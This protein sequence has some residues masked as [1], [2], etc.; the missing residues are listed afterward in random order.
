M[1]LTEAT[2]IVQSVTNGLLTIVG[3]GAAVALVLAVVRYFTNGANPN[4][5]QQLITRCIHVVG[6][7]ACIGLVL[8]FSAPFAASLM[9]NSTSSEIAS[10]AK[11][12]NS[13][14]PQV[15][16]K[17]KKHTVTEGTEIAKSKNLGEALKKAA[18]AQVAAAGL[19][20]GEATRLDSGAMVREMLDANNK[21]S[22]YKCCVCGKLFDKKTDAISCANA[23]AAAA[24]EESKNTVDEV[25]E[26]QKEVA[27]SGLTNG[28][29]IH[30]ED[31][32]VYYYEMVDGEGKVKAYKCAYDSK[33]FETK[34]EVV[35]YCKKIAKE[36]E[37]AQQQAAA[38]TQS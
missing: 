32:F 6:A 4:A 12:G 8:N 16:V 31:C 23:G 18:A 10:D 1:E 33:L 27:A 24:K 2:S 29:Q 17:G 15:D 11:S 35:A 14:L 34:R 3:V 28:T 37:N 7:V 38:G 19:H 20:D 26:N 9:E 13:W 25:I 22:K 36:M 21:V 30:I 5:R